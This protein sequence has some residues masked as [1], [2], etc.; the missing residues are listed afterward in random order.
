[1]SVTF[2]GISGHVAGI[3]PVTFAG[4]SVTF[5]ESPVTLDRNT[6]VTPALTFPPL[7]SLVACTVWSELAQKW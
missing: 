1:V 2:V 4:L 7:V 5:P 6:Q 3:L